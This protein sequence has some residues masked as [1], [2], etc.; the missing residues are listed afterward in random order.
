L[1][2]LILGGTAQASAL[3]AAIASDAGI[4]ATLSLAGRT[5]TP[6]V[7]PIKTRIGGFGGAEGLAGYLA[8]ERID[9]V[10]DA[11]HPFA[12]QISANAV[13]ACATARM[14][15]AVFSRAAWA[16]Q[17]GDRWTHVAE[18]AGAVAALGP[19][20]RHVFL[21]VGR[22]ALG[23]FAAAPQH[24][25]L[26][27]TIEALD[28]AALFPR[29]RAIRARAPFSVEDETAL[30]RSERIDCLVTKNSGGA[31]AAAKLA[32]AR[33]LGL[34]VIIVARP[35]A[36]GAERFEQLDDVLAWIARHRSAP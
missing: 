34:E 27:R 23:A 31:A 12:A 29:Q 33:A 4:D 26:I 35:A 19:A 15:L 14:P 2:L 7:F 10:I 24:F 1:R 36:G 17:Y 20:P 6:N 16:Q 11:T 9:A 25:Y 32:A 8:A 28:A 13:T 21:T 30:M 3:A 18:M 22:L 5:Q